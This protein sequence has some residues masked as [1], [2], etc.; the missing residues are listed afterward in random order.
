M[1][2]KESKTSQKLGGRFGYFLFFLLFGGAGTGRRSPRRKGEG[3][4]RLGNREGGG[5]SEERRRGEAHRGW[6]VVGGGGVEIL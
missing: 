3:P 5:G 2:R 6:E 4:C 1:G